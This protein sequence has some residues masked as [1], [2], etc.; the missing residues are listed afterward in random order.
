MFIKPQE[1]RKNASYLPFELLFWLKKT[2]KVIAVSIV[3]QVSQLNDG[4]FL[5]PSDPCIVK[6]F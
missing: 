1:K 2:L 5:P 6:K 3:S 4:E